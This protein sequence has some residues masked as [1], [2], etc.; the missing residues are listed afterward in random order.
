MTVTFRPYQAGD[1][2]AIYQVF[3]ESVTDLGRRLGTQ[4]VTDG[5]DP[6]VMRRLWD[7]RR[8]LFEHLANTADHCWVAE[9]DGK[10]VGYARSIRRENIRQLTEFFVSPH[11]QAG[12]VGRELLANALPSK[13]AERR[14]IIASLDAPA[15]IRYMKT[16]V[17][18][19]FPIGHFSRRA[20]ATA[21]ETDLTIA[22]ISAASE[23]VLTAI[24][25]V[26]REIIGYR[27]DADHRWLIDQRQGFLYTRA[28]RVV[29]YGYVGN[30]NG[31]FA[32]LDEQDYAAVLAHAESEAAQLGYVF[33][34]ET[35]MH[36]RQVIAYCLERGF[37]METFYEFFMSEGKF[38]R[39]EN[40]V[41]TT[42]PFFT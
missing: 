35:P 22:P 5:D 41:F 38:G 14:V 12:G 3:L 16:Q 9:R 40:Y 18:P 19:Q 7:R 29:G 2:H 15:L 4:A 30:Y 20:Q 17:Y 28:G 31:P 34:V 27:R 37:V 24:G 36:N 21:Y 25:E 1:I 10:I 33:G 13:G 32:L 6:E 39:Y 26:D 42:P 23:D 8:P 11:A